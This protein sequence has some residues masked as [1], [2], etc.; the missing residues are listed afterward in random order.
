[1][2]EKK[3]EQRPQYFY[4]GED[5]KLV[6]ESNKGVWVD[7][8]QYVKMYGNFTCNAK[9]MGAIIQHFKGIPVELGTEEK[10]RHT[11][12]DVVDEILDIHEHTIEHYCILGVDKDRIKEYEE[13]LG[14]RHYSN[15]RI[16][17]AKERAKK[18]EDMSHD[19]SR[20][21]SEKDGYIKKY[22]DEISKHNCLPWYKRMFHKIHIN[23]NN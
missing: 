3:L 12:D 10:V 23:F 20:L 9:T 16:T 6:V 22:V 1:M 14:E 13:E 18:F 2:E 5:G 17:K 7:G 4:F 15:V 8:E 21:V 19:L 11:K